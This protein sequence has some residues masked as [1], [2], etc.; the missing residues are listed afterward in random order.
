[1]AV[2][3]AHIPVTVV[4]L[5]I[6]HEVPAH[7]A[8]MQNGQVVEL[9]LSVEDQLPVRVDFDPVGV[10]PLQFVKRA[11]VQGFHDFAEVVR[12]GLRRIGGQVDENETVVNVG[13]YRG[14][15]EAGL[16][17]IEEV[18]LV[19]DIDEA[20]RGVVA[21]VGGTG[22]GCSCPAAAFPSSRTMREP[23]WEQTLWKPRTVSVRAPKDQHGCADRPGCRG[24]NNR[25]SPGGRR[26]ARR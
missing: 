17:E 10:G 20:A 24:R 23:R 9:V 1:M 19:R 13:V 12:K 26:P 3:E 16:V 4:P 21:P 14:E 18:L 5:G 25:P 15:T 22:R 8:A 11:A 2:V 6:P 7:D